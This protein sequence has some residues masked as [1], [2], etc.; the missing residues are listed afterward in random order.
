MPLIDRFIPD[1]DVRDEHHIGI[2]APADLVNSARS[3]RNSSPPLP[4]RIS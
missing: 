4:N 2:H 3:P 1:P